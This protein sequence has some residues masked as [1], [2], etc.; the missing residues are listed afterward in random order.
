MDIYHYA[1]NTQRMEIISQFIFPQTDNLL[2]FRLE[3]FGTFFPLKV[4]NLKQKNHMTDSNSKN[5]ST[6][7]TNRH[8]DQGRDYRGRFI[9]TQKVSQVQ[10]KKNTG[11]KPIANGLEDSDYAHYQRPDENVLKK[12]RDD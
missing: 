10:E 11:H 2:A 9:S 6:R 12:M 5:R 7:K 1:A 8:F 4:Q 3:H